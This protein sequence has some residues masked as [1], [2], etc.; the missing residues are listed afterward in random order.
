MKG[1]MRSILMNQDIPTI[2]KQLRREYLA[3]RK[4]LSPEI[5]QAKS[6]DLVRQLIEKTDWATT[7]HIHCF[8]PLAGDNEPDVRAFVEYALQHGASI[9]TTDPALATGR[10]VMELK[11]RELQQQI[12]QFELEKKAEFDLI[13]VPMIAYDPATRHRLGFGG[14]FYD[15]L[16][17]MQPWAHS[18]GVC[19]SELACSLPSEAHDA[20]V[21]ELLLA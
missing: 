7:R 19:F 15:K 5:A 16:L 21:D 3:R 12:Q 20:A 6:G 14:G 18:I 2:K 8:L 9:S 4:A 10:Q 11:D 17:A 13:I 1:L